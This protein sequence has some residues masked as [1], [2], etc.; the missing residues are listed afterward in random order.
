MS[1]EGGFS[2]RANKLVDGCY[3]F[4]IGGMWPIIDE[5]LAI[6]SDGPVIKLLPDAVADVDGRLIY[7]RV[8]LQEYLLACCQAPNGGLLDKPGTST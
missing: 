4:W 6:P 3:S 5:A 8:A 7:D 2:G 1:V